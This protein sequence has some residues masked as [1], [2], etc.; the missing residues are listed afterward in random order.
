[1]VG[2]RWFSDQQ[3]EFERK[4]LEIIYH[5]HLRDKLAIR[6]DWNLILLYYLVFRNYYKTIIRMAKLNR[7]CGN[8]ARVREHSNHM[9]ALL[10]VLLVDI[11]RFITR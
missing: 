8:V 5:D 3:L 6:P 10:H 9:L 7:R 4:D 2:E 1:M 11:A